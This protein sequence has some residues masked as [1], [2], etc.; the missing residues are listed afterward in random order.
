MAL[1]SLLAL[2]SAKVVGATADE[3][4]L[5]LESAGAAA[6]SVNVVTGEVHRAGIYGKLVGGPDVSPEYGST[7]HEDFLARVHPEDRDA[8]ASSPER[9]LAAGGSFAHEFR[10]FWPDGTMRWLTTRG[11]VLAD[12]DGRPVA[13]SGVLMDITKSK[14][15]EGELAVLF[16]AER[17]ARAEAERATATAQ[18]RGHRLAQLE[19]LT[20]AGL[21][22]LSV[23]E[24]LAELLE[25]V[26]AALAVDVVVV[27]LLAAD[28]P[29]IMRAAV[30]VDRL[31]V[32]VTGAEDEP[33]IGQLRPGAQPLVLE[34]I[35]EVSCPIP[36]LRGQGLRSLVEVPLVV[37]GRPTGVL[38][39]GTRK[40]RHFSPSD[41][42]LLQLAADRMA[43]AIDRVQLFEREHSLAETLQRSLLPDTL[44]DL[45]EGDLAGIYRP[46][47][48]ATVGGDWY[49]VI[50]LPKGQVALVMGDVVGRGVRA[51]SIMGQLRAACRIY[52]GQGHGPGEVVRFLNRFALTLGRGE[53]ATLVYLALD[54]S[55]GEGVLVSAGH[56]PPLVRYAD[57]RCEYLC[58]EPNLPLGVQA[59]ARYVEHPVVV[60]ADSTVLL[61]TDGLMERRDSTLEAGFDR[62]T[63]AMAAAPTG[64]GEACTHVLDALLG[65]EQPGDDIALLA[66]RRT[67]VTAECLELCLPAEATAL[68]QLR[69]VLRNWLGQ[70]GANEEEVYDLVLAVSE[71]AANVSEHAYGPV[72]AQYQFTATVDEGDVQLVVKDF[73]QWRPPRGSNRGRGLLLM[74]A[75][76]HDV[77]IRHTDKGTEVRLG[78]RLVG[79]TRA[80]QEDGLVR[81]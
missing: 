21:A 15:A 53:M 26:Q 32:G 10:L 37:E 5:A 4:Q 79:P 55:S 52:A 70:M 73:G 8:I 75:L 16:D 71:A 60:P 1:S 25:R 81:H 38:Q 19:T 36:H 67:N 78:R 42:Q 22:H 17:L 77:A 64:P 35:D 20:E 29:L 68:P 14:E 76:A 54:P 13:V 62:L 43:L 23:D 39:I 18:A 61:Y 24:L 80:H 34:D 11:R 72:E 3:L 46:G 33:R 63:R 28:G 58:P 47:A 57:D 51:A 30:G 69:R 56:P 41:V 2:P 48:G 7:D 40:S 31:D 6:W 44:P 50:P 65:E 74:N 9:I 49:D 66:M 59:S 27:S 45:P 12:P